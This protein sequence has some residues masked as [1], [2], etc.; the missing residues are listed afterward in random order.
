[1]AKSQKLGYVA[2]KRLASLRSE[3]SSEPA[4]ASKQEHAAW[5]ESVVSRA[6]ALFRM[7]GRKAAL[8]SMQ[9]SESD[10]LLELLGE[11]VA[12]KVAARA[13]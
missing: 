8:A 7:V 6:T 11:T 3:M 10:R 9:P 12:A 1:M 13:N 5:R 2:G 4:S